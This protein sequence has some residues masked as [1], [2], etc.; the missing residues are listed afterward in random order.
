MQALDEGGNVFVKDGW[1]PEREECQHMATSYKRQTSVDS[2]D[3]LDSQPIYPNND[4][5]FSMLKFFL[6][7]TFFL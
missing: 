5:T 7:D 4:G 2:I 6:H 3:S 1:C